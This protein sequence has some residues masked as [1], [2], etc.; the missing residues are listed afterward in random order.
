MT[1]VWS[2]WSRSRD[3]VPLKDLLDRIGC[4][5]ESTSTQRCVLLGPTHSQ[6]IEIVM[7]FTTSE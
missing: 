1:S 7:G 4:N 2:P 6:P 5:Y 3:A